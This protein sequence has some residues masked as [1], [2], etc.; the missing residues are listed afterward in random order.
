MQKE[1]ELEEIVKLV[2]MDA[3][4]ATDRLLLET[5]RSVREDYLHQDAF[6]EVDTFT[7]VKKQY[8]MLLLVL[9]FY[10]LSL[11]ALKRGADIE[12]IAGLSVRDKISR[13]KYALEDEIKAEYE[14]ISKELERETEKLKEV[15]E[16]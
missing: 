11:D 5:A 3:L 10:D 15:G 13:F 7:S 12:K 16:D 14:R 6:H 8:L 9:K 4:S 1:A 2:G